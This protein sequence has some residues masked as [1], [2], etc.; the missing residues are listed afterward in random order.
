MMTKQQSRPIIA[1]IAAVVLLSLAGFT[2]GAA[3]SDVADAVMKGDRAAVTRL[4]AQKAD[5]NAPQV[6]GA[7]AV[8]WAVFND[9]T[10]T[11]DAL[12]AAGAKVK[13]SNREGI[14]P[15]AMASLYGK[16]EVVTKLLKA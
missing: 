13:V 1:G 15:L 10:A 7:T 8:H 4:L 14:S 16:T 5:V 6:D 9:D 3:R 12:I 2:F 11:L